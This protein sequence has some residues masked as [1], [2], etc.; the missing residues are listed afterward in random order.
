MNEIEIA[1]RLTKVEERAKSNTHQIDEL[2]PV[3]NEIHT[4][5]KT[6][7]QLVGEVQHTNENVVEL[8]EKVE[9]L[10]NEPAERWNSMRRTIF[11]TV[12]STV[13]G[14]LV[15]AILTLIL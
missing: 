5:S 13:A 6:M 2:K 14:A 1:E 12:V 8:K 15:G 4:M 7:V 11:T 10:E 9:T 3:V